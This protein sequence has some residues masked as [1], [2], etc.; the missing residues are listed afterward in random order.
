MTRAAVLRDPALAAVS[1]SSQRSSPRSSSAVELSAIDTR[2][3]GEIE[4]DVV[5]FARKPN[6][7]LVVTA[8]GAPITVEVDLGAGREHGVQ[9][10]PESFG[11]TACWFVICCGERGSSAP[12]KGKPRTSPTNPSPWFRAAAKYMN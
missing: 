1:A 2:D 12:R 3:V 4:C 9:P 11:R 6:G 8:S 10:I 7:G 5:A